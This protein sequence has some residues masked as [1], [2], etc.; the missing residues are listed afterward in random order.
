MRGFSGQRT[1]RAPGPASADADI[2]DGVRF[3]VI[4]TRMRDGVFG[5]SRHG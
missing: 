3:I 2:V 5:A 1:R 4:V